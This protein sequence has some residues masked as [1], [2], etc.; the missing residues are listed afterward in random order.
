MEKYKRLRILGTG[1]FSKVF[2]VQDGETSEYF[3]VKQ[4]EAAMSSTER[5]RALQEAALLRV[6]QHPNIVSYKEAFLTRSGHICLIMEFAEGGDLHQYMQGQRHMGEMVSEMKVLDWFGQICQALQYLHGLNIIHRDIKARNIFLRATGAVQLGDFG[7][8]TVAD[9]SNGA[10][11][12]AAG[13]PTY[14]S[15]ERVLRRPYGASADIWSLGIVVYELCALR[16][17]FEAEALP[18]L[19]ERILSGE[20]APLD[21]RYY[22]PELR[23]VVSRMLAQQPD[24]RPS[25]SELLNCTLLSRGEFLRSTSSDFETVVLTSPGREGHEPPIRVHSPP[26]PP[27]RGPSPTWPHGAAG[28]TADYLTEPVFVPEMELVDV[29]ADVHAGCHDSPSMTPKPAWATNLPE[30]HHQNT[31]RGP[32]IGS[33]LLHGARRL[34]GFERSH[35]YGGHS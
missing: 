28:A 2:L 34:L 17:P 20:Y 24:A 8:S 16:R 27:M 14:A 7:I 15:P 1:S 30:K 6:L 11:S 19:A 21:D 10:V 32:H 35:T 13:T 25:A 29:E 5:E 31:T 23:C 22:S 4:I 18:A 12:H 26:P 3:V 9:A 33:S